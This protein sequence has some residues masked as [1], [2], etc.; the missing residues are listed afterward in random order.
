MLDKRLQLGGLQVGGPRTMQ[1]VA[2]FRVANNVYHTRGDYLVPRFHC[3]QELEF[4]PT[5][6]FTDPE[7]VAL[8]DYKSV[9]FCA[10]K[11]VDDGYNFYYQ[12]AKIPFL[13]EGIGSPIDSSTFGHSNGYGIQFVE[14]LGCLFAHFPIYG[15]FKFDGFQFYKAGVPLPFFS[16]AQYAAAGATYVRV[17]QHHN[18]LQG[19]IVNS[20]YL[21][22]RATP[23]ASLITIRTD[24]ATTDIIGSG[25]GIVPSSRPMGEILT[26]VFDEFFFKSSAQV[27]GATDI[28]FTTGGNHLA[29]VDAYIMVSASLEVV[30]DTGL[31]EDSYGISMKVSAVTANTVTLSLVDVKYLDYNLDWQTVTM[32][33]TGSF[34]ATITYGTNYWVSVWTS[35]TETGNYVYKGIGPVLYNSTVSETFDTN[36]A[37]PTVAA[38]GSTETAFNLAGNLGDIYDVTTVKQLFPHVRSTQSTPGYPYSFSTYG[39]LALISTANEVNFSDTSLGGAFE[40]MNGLSF[41]VVGDGDDGTIQLVC[42]NSDFFLVSR[43]RKNYYVSG[44]LPTANYRVQTINETSLGGY[45]N[46]SAISYLDKIIF[47]NKAGIWGVFAGGRCEE[48]S[49]NIRGYF[50]DWSESYAFAEEDYWDIDDFPSFID[51][52]FDPVFTQNY[53]VR[54]RADVSRGLIAVMISGSD[55]T[56]EALILNMNN[57]EFTTWDNFAGGSVLTGPNVKDICFIDGGYFLALNDD[58]Q[59]YLYLEFKTGATRYGYGGLQLEGSWFTAMEPSLEKKLNQLKLWGIITAPV[60][61]SHYLDWSTTAAISD[62]TY[63]NTVS[64][65]FSHKQRL[66][67]ANFQSVSIV[68]SVTP[69]DKV[70]QIE[71]IEVEWQPFQQG[72]KK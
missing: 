26:G 56:G 44:N 34:L 52:D 13:I 17:I 63:T 18:D 7:I 37:S 54:M 59:A 9:P 29:E 35:N 65:K 15:L 8:A 53:W 49:Y 41:I 62:G 67:P 43:K 57:G 6:S 1:N 46:E 61:I 71:G 10:V 20:A 21:Q 24:T 25:T 66:N 38:T 58:T 28:V 27:I 45:S 69:G 70:F 50:T 23:A 33:N 68:M 11:Q 51:L 48:I 22:F 4:P 55:D 64:N 36:V 42:G 32:P 19:N 31:P 60:V 2:R 72:M 3:A 47:M 14:K 12:G 30:A 39:E 5:V 16:C 40:M